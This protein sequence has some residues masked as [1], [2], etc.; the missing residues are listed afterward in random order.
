MRDAI[1]SKKLVHSQP[2]HY[3]Q[4]TVSLA[5]AFANQAAIAIENAQLYARA[6]EMATLEERTR[7]AR[8]LHDSATQALYSA[9]LFSET[10]KKLAA[11]GDLAGSQHYQERAGDVIQQALKEMRLLVYELR[12]PELEAEGLAG[13]LQMRLDAV[14]SRVGMEARL[15]TGQLQDLPVEVVQN[16]Y[17]IALEALNNVLKHARADSVTVTL[18]SAD[19]ALLLE[20]ADN[21]QGFDPDAVRDGGGLGLIGIQERVQAL[22]GKLV[23]DSSPEKGTNLSVRV[24]VLS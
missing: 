19:D 17:R 15:I 9:L 23:I 7:L 2:H 22:G 20:V 3:D 11:G 5:Q 16:L 10:G 18:R 6:Q 13:A 21:G 24:E 4:E 14:E 1:L 12:P 8:E